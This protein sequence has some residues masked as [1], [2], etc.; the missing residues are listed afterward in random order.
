[1]FR[2]S[3]ILV[4]LVLCILLLGGQLSALKIV[5]NLN[6]WGNYLVGCSGGIKTIELQPAYSGMAHYSTDPVAVS[7][8]MLHMV[9]LKGERY[10]PNGFNGIGVGQ[11]S[12]YWDDFFNG[13]AEWD[14]SDLP[15][16]IKI[17]NVGLR[18]K[19][20]NYRNPVDYSYFD[21]D[22]IWL[23]IYDMEHRPSNRFKKEN[24]IPCDGTIFKDSCELEENKNKRYYYTRIE[25]LKKGDGYKPSY[26]EWYYLS[27]AAT[28]DLQNHLDKGWFALGFCDRG[29]KDEK[30]NPPSFPYSL[31]FDYYLDR[32]IVIDPEEIYLK[33]VYINKNVENL[34]P[35]AY[36]DKI[37]PSSIVKGEKVT[38]AGHGVDPDG[39]GIVEYRWKLDNKVISTSKSFSTSDIP[40]GMHIISFEV[41]DSAGGWSYPVS[42]ILAVHGCD[43]KIENP[44][45]GRIYVFNR[46]ILSTINSTNAVVLGDITIQAKATATEANIE[47]IDL[48]VDGN[49]VQSYKSNIVEWTGNLKKG[50]H[51]IKVLAYDS[52]NRSA[53]DTIKIISLI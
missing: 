2:K 47:K 3:L 21:D 20:L 51:Y 32:G 46:E 45:R 49:L 25:A 26:N 44:K 41:K 40:V 15:K 6:P 36:I 28:K 37:K 43:V 19:V 1:M 12:D 48:Y 33:I 50:E 9:K 34:P 18:L 10:W 42:A 27:E 14:L 22:Y 23:D 53:T 8:Y 24:S 31:V 13:F 52:R 5:K 39:G 7:K 16:D 4:A 11:D 35:S 29:R 30:W 17:L 38:I